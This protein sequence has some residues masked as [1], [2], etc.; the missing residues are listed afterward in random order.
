[1]KTFP[2]RSYLSPT[3][4]GGLYWGP[5]IEAR[6]V[7]RYKRFLV[8]VELTDGTPLTA[9]TANT[10]SMLGCSEPD[11]RVWL[12]RHDQPHRKYAHTLEMIEM[13]SALVGVNTGVPNRLVKAAALAGRIAGFPFPARVSCEVRHGESR[14]DLLLEKEGEPPTFVEIKN[15]TLAENGTASFP[16]AV[17]ARGARHLEELANVV[18]EGKRAIIFILIQRA[19]V[20]RFLPADHIDPEWGRA[21]RR[22]LAEGV[23]LLAYRADLNCETI[24]LGERVPLGDL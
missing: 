16:D 14:L 6:L 8:D 24:S 10:G 4:D 15:C 9:H 11:R 13:P 3:P 12:S 17:T 5:L 2:P 18:R 1:M 7:R 22:V 23:E 20:V 19:D 21:L